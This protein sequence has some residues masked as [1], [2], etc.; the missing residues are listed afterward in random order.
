MKPIYIAAFLLASSL[1]LS[2]Q[3]QTT[4]T[5]T[6]TNAAA[7]PQAT[8]PPINLGPPTNQNPV[9]TQS[10]VK[11]AT[12]DIKDQTATDTKVQQ[13]VTGT[14]SIQPNRDVKL[15]P[16]NKVKATSEP[17]EISKLRA[18]KKSGSSTTTQ[19]TTPPRP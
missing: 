11:Q 6:S 9:V 13:A 4:P 16:A 10:P 7:L 1:S 5:P 3:A 8:V 18:A 17:S 2:A 19:P 12:I 15:R 14:G